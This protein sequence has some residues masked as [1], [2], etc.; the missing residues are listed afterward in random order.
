MPPHS[1]TNFE[2]DKYYQNEPK[3][4]GVCSRKNLPKSKG[5]SIHN[6]STLIQI[7]KNSLD[8]FVREW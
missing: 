7:N 3:V 2:I 5:W 1:L 4:N 6:F 8:S